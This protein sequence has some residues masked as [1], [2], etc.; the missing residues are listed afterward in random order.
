LLGLAKNHDPP[1]LCLLSGWDY[2]REPPV[3]GQN[4]SIW[5]MGNPLEVFVHETEMQVPLPG[6]F[7]L[8]T[9]SVK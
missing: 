7:F 3:P 5:F 8:V 9:P 2:R 6:L 4:F 1:D